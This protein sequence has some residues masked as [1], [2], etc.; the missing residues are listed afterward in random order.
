M[1]TSPEHDDTTGVTAEASR[2]E[3]FEQPEPITQYTGE[4]IQ[5]LE[6]LEPVRHRPAMYIG[7]TVLKGYHH[8]VYEVVDNSVDEVLAGIATKVE[9]IIHP[10]ESLTVI[11]DG[12]GIPVDIQ[13][14]T[15]K[16][17]LEVVMTVLHAG[18]KFSGG[19]YK[20]SGGLH[21]VGVSCV[22]ALSEWLEVQVRRDGN[23]YRMR[24]ERGK[25][26]TGVE[27]IG[28]CDPAEHG[29]RVTF[30]SDTEQIFVP[31]DDFVPVY[32]YDILATRLRELAFLNRGVRIELIDE[33]EGGR[34]DLF[35]FEGGIAEFVRELNKNKDV[36]HP[37]PIELRFEAEVESPQ[38]EKGQMRVELAMQYNSGYSEMI[39]SYANNINTREGGV[40]V[41]GFSAALYKIINDFARSSGL[42]KEKELDLEQADTREGLVAVV[43]VQHPWP[44]FEG[45]TKGK[46][47]N[48]NVHGII[49]RKTLEVFGEFVE[50]NPSLGKVLVYKALQAAKARELAHKAKELVRRKGALDSMS[51][52]GKLADCTERDPDKC[53]LYIVEGDSAGG[54]AKQGRNRHFQA[55][56]PLRGKILNVEKAREDKALEN[57]EI[58]NLV[59]AMGCSYGPE[60]NPEK[61]KYKKI[62]LMTDAD[63]DGSH[64]RTLLLTFMYRWMKAVLDGGYVYIAQPPLYKIKKSNKEHYAYNDDEK[65]RILAEI[66]SERVEIQRYKGLGEMDAEQL[67]ETTMDPEHRIMRQVTLEDAVRADEMFT[68]LMGDKVEPRRD[69]IQAHA[70]EVTDLDI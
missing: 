54:S 59:T 50:E 51:L 35:H 5:V 70:K 3:S 9:V 40:H 42:L 28:S 64:I 49:S 2:Q 37:E 18:G 55:I 1:T 12:R 33:R 20:V 43:S 53:E 68:V 57:E 62:I 60:C 65:A 48:S 8:L 46:L 26:V 16:P 21:G 44:Q 14:S 7:D 36:L 31:S 41:R 63:V 34:R 23:I 4:N 27:V 56:L 52:P 66:G 17:A 10:D 30:K 19:G 58:R 6:G 38:G 24:F 39:N 32:R 47:G 11:D 67:W 29:T 22:N 15:G 25:A 45:Q 61:L 69:F 13:P